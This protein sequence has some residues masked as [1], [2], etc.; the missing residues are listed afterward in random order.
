M[1][2]FAPKAIAHKYTK[3]LPPL[4]AEPRLA[5]AMTRFAKESQ[6]LYLLCGRVLALRILKLKKI[7]C[8]TL[9]L[10]EPINMIEKYCIN[11]YNT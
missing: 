8:H 1:P 10:S 11:L 5:S 2:T 4:K 6:L 3:E 9:G 7:I